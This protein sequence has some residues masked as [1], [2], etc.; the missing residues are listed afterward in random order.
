MR[1]HLRKQT[2]LLQYLDTSSRV[3]VASFLSEVFLCLSLGSRWESL[4]PNWLTW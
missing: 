1:P 4:L 2:A 3:L